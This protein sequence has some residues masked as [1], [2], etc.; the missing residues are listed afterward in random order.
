MGPA[1]PRIV[2]NSIDYFLL[3]PGNNYFFKQVLSESDK[4]WKNSLGTGFSKGRDG[5][6]CSVVW[7]SSLRSRR[8]HK[9]WK[10]DAGGQAESS[11]FFTPDKP[12]H[13]FT[14][15]GGRAE[16]G[17][18]MC[19]LLKAGREELEKKEKTFLWCR[20]TQ[21]ASRRNVF[22]LGLWSLPMSELSGMENCYLTQ[23]PSNGGFC[24]HLLDCRGHVWGSRVLSLLPTSR[25]S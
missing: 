13:S 4:S 24:C 8:R 18:R 3:C 12:Q 15:C 16:G 9:G 19:L 2:L 17:T 20:R 1:F 25:G 6:S 21:C 14:R 5:T 7:R 11:P 10:M 23:G 22:C